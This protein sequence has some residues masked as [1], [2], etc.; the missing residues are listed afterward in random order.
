MAVI[1]ERLEPRRPYGLAAAADNQTDTSAGDRVCRYVDLKDVVGTD[2]AKDYA[3]LFNPAEDPGSPVRDVAGC[4]LL[5]IIFLFAVVR[6]S[7]W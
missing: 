5:I 3:T 7:P 2:L 1:D 6:S 4:R